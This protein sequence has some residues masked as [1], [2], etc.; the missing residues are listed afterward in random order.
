[1]YIDLYIYIYIYQIFGINGDKNYNH[2]CLVKPDLVPV[3]EM[4]PVIGEKHKTLL[5]SRLQ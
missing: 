3:N 2:T 1:M 5:R 4:L